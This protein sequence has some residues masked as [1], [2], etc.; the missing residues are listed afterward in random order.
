MGWWSSMVDGI[1]TVGS[2]I[3]QGVSWTRANAPWLLTECKAVASELVAVAKWTVNNVPWI[4]VDVCKLAGS[5]AIAGAKWSWN[6]APL[7]LAGCK[8]VG[9][10]L[11]TSAKWAKDNVSLSGIFLG[12]RTFSRN[13]LLNVR[14]Y[15]TA[16]PKAIAT[17]KNNRRAQKISDGA[18]Y[19]LRHNVLIILT[20]NAINNKIQAHFF[21][22]SQDDSWQTE[23]LLL[24]VAAGTTLSIDVG[25]ALFG[26]L[27]QWLTWR[28]GIEANSQ[29]AVLDIAGPGA[30]LSADT[31]T[32]HT[33]CVQLKCTWKRQ[34]DGLILKEPVVLIA[35]DVLAWLI[36]YFNSP[37]AIVLSA[38]FQARYAYRVATP[39]RC[40]RHKEMMQEAVLALVLTQQSVIMLMNYLLE[41][42]IGMPPFIYYRV[43]QH[44]LLLFHINVAAHMDLPL[45]EKKDSTLP[46]DLLRFYER[47]S[48]FVA[49]VIFSGLMKRIPIDFKP[50]KDKAPFISL[51]TALNFCTKRLNDNWHVER[52]GM[53]MR[54]WDAVRYAALPPMFLGVDNLLKD[55]IVCQYSPDFINATLSTL[56]TLKTYRRS[57]ITSAIFWFSKPLI[58]LIHY[59]TGIPKKALKFSFALIGKKA[60]WEFIDALEGWCRRHNPSER[61]AVYHDFDLSELRPSQLVK[62]PNLPGK[63]EAI[64]PEQ[65][66]LTDNPFLALTAERLSET[67][68]SAL[69]VSAEQLTIEHVVPTNTPV[70]NSGELSEVQPSN[71]PSPLP[72]SPLSLTS[73]PASALSTSAL[74]TDKI[75]SLLRTPGSM[76]EAI[77]VDA[78]SLLGPS[79]RFDLVRRNQ[80]KP[81]AGSSQPAGMFSPSLSVSLNPGP[82]VLPHGDV[83]P[84]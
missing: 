49:D 16:V 61:H 15:I 13:T 38:F 62:L 17:L 51:P 78:N 1:K 83:M 55:P 69:S 65:L 84:R 67:R 26:Y 12:T 34:A 72:V 45:V 59:S 8:S 4:V 74:S 42:T 22:E 52:P 50:E 10:G 27:V 7:L 43:L 76:K 35:N 11:I 25:M 68:K 79:P 39:E 37:L 63:S 36:S 21:N 80:Q 31:R 44:L 33:L 20:L 56:E 64:S 6:K 57:K 75:R 47:C 24:P 5:G 66:S 23:D 2:G 82:L 58:Q 60:F 71:E 30:F 81:L 70:Q 29:L 28:K 48:R 54:S 53:V 3:S 77:S 14:A 73:V 19:I 9:S 18:V 41:S 46:F 40:E 32:P